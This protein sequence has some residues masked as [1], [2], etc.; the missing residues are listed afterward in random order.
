M[1]GILP[2]EVRDVKVAVIMG[3]RSPE[4]AV[5]RAS[6][7]NVALALKQ[8]GFDVVVLEAEADLPLRLREAGVEAA[9]LATHG[10]FGEDGTL[11]GM[12]EFMDIPYTGSGVLAS[13]L[14]MHKAMAKGIFKLEGIPT[15]PWVTWTE[16]DVKGLS[17]TALEAVLG[18]RGLTLPVVV[19][20]CESGSAI[21]IQMVRDAA[22]L[23]QA[24]EAALAY[25]HEVLVEPLL[26]GMEITVGVL[27]SGTLQA[28]PATEIVPTGGFYDFDSKYR[29]GGS[30]HILPARLH[31]DILNRAGDIAVRAHRALGCFGMSRV[32]MIVSRPVPPTGTAEQAAASELLVLE[33]NTLPG[34]TDTSL[35]PEACA[36]AGLG[37]P[38]VTRM[39]IE[40]AVERLRRS[41]R[42]GREEPLPVTS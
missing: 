18:R 25:G 33:V 8:A 6:G 38:E 30:E 29:T 21:G 10:T 34:M 1:L 40:W 28:L 11:Q 24:A 9:F 27:G 39:Q 12:L 4:A 36:K 5:S 23:C 2:F 22:H 3:G 41:R 32:D 19:K 17:A 26:Q 7:K 14:A 37:F 13:A 42:S 20:P 35:Y 31:A 15:A 16:D